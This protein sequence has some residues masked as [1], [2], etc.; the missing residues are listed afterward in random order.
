VEPS[1]SGQVAWLVALTLVAVS[2]LLARSA[3]TR[4]RLAPQVVRL[5]AWAAAALTPED[6]PDPLAEAL[7]AQLRRERLVADVQRLRRLMAHDQ[8]MSAVRQLGN[9]IAYASLVAELESLREA[10]TAS[11]FGTVGLPA[12]ASVPTSRWTDDLVLSTTAPRSPA[13]DLGQRAPAVEVLE[14]GPRRRT[15]H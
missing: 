15:A 7:R 10:P 13:R 5:L 6:E 12:A 2:L 3:A 4:R 8:H 1:G 14:L 11:P 9:R